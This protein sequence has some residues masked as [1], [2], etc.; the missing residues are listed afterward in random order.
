MCQSRSVRLGLTVTRPDGI[1]SH[2]LSLKI[3]LHKP[4]NIKD[5]LLARLSA[6]IFV[7]GIQ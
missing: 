1:I 3:F 5:V 4:R 2:N 7:C 6:P